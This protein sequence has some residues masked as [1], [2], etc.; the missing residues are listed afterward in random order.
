MNVRDIA[1]GLAV[2]VEEATFDADL[3]VFGQRNPDPSWEAKVGD[4]YRPPLL[5]SLVNDGRR[6]L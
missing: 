4:G 3:S 2:G 1:V 6:R 5:G